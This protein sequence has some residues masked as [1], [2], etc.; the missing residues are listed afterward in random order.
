MCS[1]G[2]LCDDAQR[3]WCRRSQKTNEEKVSQSAAC[4]CH[5]P[6]VCVFEYTDGVVLRCLYLR[7]SELFHVILI[8][9]VFHLHRTIQSNYRVILCSVRTKSHEWNPVAGRGE[10]LSGLKASIMGLQ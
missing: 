3:A 8:V 2:I 6:A 4:T 1:E 9:C 10:L 7:L 5:P